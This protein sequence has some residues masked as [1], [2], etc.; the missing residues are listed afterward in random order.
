MKNEQELIFRNETFQIIGAAM[1]VHKILGPG[2]LEAVY[3]EAMEIELTARKIPFESHKKL[4][5]PYKSHILKQHYEADFLVYDKIIV[6]IKAL[7]TLITKHHAQV[8]NYLKATKKRV[9]LLIN[10]GE[11]SLVNKRFIL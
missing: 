4:R 5:I 11:M 3:H 9:G 6:E 1:E 8:L 10:F 7:D 2:F